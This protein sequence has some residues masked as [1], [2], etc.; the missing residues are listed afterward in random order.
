MS[1]ETIHKKN[2]KQMDLLGY[3][4]NTCNN[5]CRYTHESPLHFLTNIFSVT[6][7]WMHA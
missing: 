3:P 2:S 4:V 7:K 6:F 5:V 1:F